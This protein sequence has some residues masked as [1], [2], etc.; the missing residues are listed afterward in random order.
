MND[1]QALEAT[2]IE[3]LQ[4][5]DLSPI[6]QARAYERLGREF[7][8]TQEQMAIRTGKDRA[9]VTNFL[10]LLRLPQDLQQAVA[11]GLLTFG[12]AR[13][14]L[15]LENP[16][17]IRRV[18]QN[19]MALSMSVR[20]TETF[21]KGILNPEPRKSKKAEK[22]RVVDPKRARD[23]EHAARGAGH[24]RRDRGQARPRPRGDRV[25]RPGRV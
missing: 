9:S 23:G 24:A 7:H 4:R 25:R 12:H 13:A 22:E 14:L 3:N 17:K 19:V 11:D 18:A 16:E 20:Q 6:E 2:I 15:S 1:A 10:R 5:A 8:M 21:V